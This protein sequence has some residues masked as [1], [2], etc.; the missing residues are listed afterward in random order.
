MWWRVEFL[1]SNYKYKKILVGA[2]NPDDVLRLINGV[3]FTV[4]TQLLH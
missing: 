3:L 2:T 1:N 4:R